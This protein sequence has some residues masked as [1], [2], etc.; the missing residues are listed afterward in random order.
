MN[1]H[2]WTCA[3]KSPNCG[4][5]QVGY[6]VQGSDILALW[7]DL[8]AQ[9]KFKD[10]N[11]M[12]KIDRLCTGL[13]RQKAEDI[14]WLSKMGAVRMTKSDALDLARAHSSTEGYHIRMVA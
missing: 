5:N 9:G 4:Y 11:E 8:K 1:D 7:M 13:A 2:C 14:D 10:W 12:E 6:P 3:G